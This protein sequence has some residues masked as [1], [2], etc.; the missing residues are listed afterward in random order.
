MLFE[1]YRDKLSY[2]VKDGSVDTSILELLSTNKDRRGSRQETEAALSQ[3]FRTAGTLFEVID[4]RTRNVIVPY[5]KQARDI[6]TRLEGEPSPAETAELL[7]KAQKYTVSIYA[8]TEKQLA[9]KGALHLDILEKRFYSS[10]F[11][12]DKDGAEQEILIF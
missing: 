1:R 2:P 4:S 6:I 9:E 8:G 3:A 7:R 10:E 11:G 12:V 5:N